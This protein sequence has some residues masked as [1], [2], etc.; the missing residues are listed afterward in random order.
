M[1]NSIKSLTRNSV[2]V[3]AILFSFVSHGA[4][5]LLGSPV[6]PYTKSSFL[7]KQGVVALERED[8]SAAIKFLREGIAQLGKGY[9][10]SGAI[11]DTDQRIFFA[12]AA[13]KNGDI[14]SAAQLL[15]RALSSRL[16]LARM[17]VPESSGK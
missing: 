13:E 9:A 4:P 16:E 10:P 2:A 8:F 1:G 11:D 15:E 12:E 7:H 14:R 17:S 5:T 3:L 6:E